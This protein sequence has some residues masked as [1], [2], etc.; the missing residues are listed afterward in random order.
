MKKFGVDKRKLHLSNLL[1]SKEITRNKALQILQQPTYSSSEAEKK[2]LN[3]F[4][5]KMNWEK[6]R[7]DSYISEG[8]VS[9][10]VYNS[11]KK[12]WEGLK[13]FYY[14]SNIAK[15]FFKKTSY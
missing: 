10:L 12:L 11:E 2:D 9:H 6:K 4:L 1:V 8:E 15:W 14:K 7:L 5:K 3:Y 13:N